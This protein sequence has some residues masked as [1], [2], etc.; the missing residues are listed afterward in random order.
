[1]H[2]TMRRHRVFP[3]IGLV[4]TRGRAVLL[5]QQIF[6]TLHIAQVRAVERG[7]GCDLA[8]RLWVGCRRLGIGRLETHAT[9]RLNRPQNDLQHVQRTAGLE[10]IGVRRNPAHR[11]K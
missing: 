11:V 10:A 1:M 5:Q 9:G 8:V 4:D 2:Q 7:A 3:C 6:G